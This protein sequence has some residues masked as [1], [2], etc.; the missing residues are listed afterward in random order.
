MENTIISIKGNLSS[1]LF[2]LISLISNIGCVA[3]RIKLKKISVNNFGFKNN[4]GL[5]MRGSIFTITI[6]RMLKIILFM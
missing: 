6:N 2:S 4:S 3:V 5:P 1:F